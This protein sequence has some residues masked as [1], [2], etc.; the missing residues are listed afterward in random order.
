MTTKKIT[1]RYFDADSFYTHIG[2]FA[3]VM[4]CHGFTKVSK[5]YLDKIVNFKQ[6]I[7]EVLWLF[8]GAKTKNLKNPTKDKNIMRNNFVREI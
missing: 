8:K 6:I 4:A 1:K 3:T 7:E 2:I 5:I